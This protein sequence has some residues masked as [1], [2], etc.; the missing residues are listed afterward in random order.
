MNLFYKQSADDILQIEQFQ[1]DAFCNSGGIKTAY[2]DFYKW[3]QIY[4]LTFN[5]FISCETDE[6]DVS[7]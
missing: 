7:I 3:K 4:Q 5:M 6:N 1:I 2:L